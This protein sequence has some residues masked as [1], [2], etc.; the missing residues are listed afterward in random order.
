[1]TL[2]TITTR[3]RAVAAMLL[4]FLIPVASAVAQGATYKYGFC[5]GVAGTSPT[6]YLTRAFV[7]GPTNGDLRAEFMRDLGAG[8]GGNVRRD[9]TGCRMFATALEAEKA[10]TEVLEQARKGPKPPVDLDWL[11]KGA[12][13]LPKRGA[14]SHDST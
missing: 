10:R 3:R 11:P 7:L 8:H 4:S 6:N 12:T 2:R 9:A 13:A 5:M 14:T 1:M